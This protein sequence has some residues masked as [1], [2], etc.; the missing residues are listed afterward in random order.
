MSNESPTYILD[1]SAGIIIRFL[2]RTHTTSPIIEY[3]EARV[4]VYRDEEGKIL[5]LEV[6]YIE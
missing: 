1:N 6:E 4:I 3:H 5:T 2:E